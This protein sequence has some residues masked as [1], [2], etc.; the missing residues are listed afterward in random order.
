MNTTITILRPY[1]F[2][3]T[4]KLEELKDTLKNEGIDDFDSFISSI[5]D[6]KNKEKIDK[7]KN[8]M[9]VMGDGKDMNINSMALLSAPNL[10]HKAWAPSAKC[11]KSG[12]IYTGDICLKTKTQWNSFNEYL[13]FD[14]LSEIGCIGCI[15]VPHHGSK[16]SFNSKLIK[17][18]C[19]Y[20]ISAGE[21]NQY[22]HPD[23]EV[24]LELLKKRV[25]TQLIT[26]ETKPMIFKY[27]I[28]DNRG[29]EIRSEMDASE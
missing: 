20:I 26:E 23:I 21:E 24:L 7:L 11:S 15:Q 25:N 4:E 28:N 9:R 27:S 8:A 29:I 17:E 22:D 13:K 5:N 3:Q 19:S 16:H 12:C 10:A 2:E 18:G 6:G 1:N 14:N